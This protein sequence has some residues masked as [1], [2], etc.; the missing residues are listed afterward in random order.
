MS[1]VRPPYDTAS[2]SWAA[3]TSYTRPPAHAADETWALGEGAVLFVTIAP[4]ALPATFA[5]I[6]RPQEPNTLWARAL[7]RPEHLSAS[8][9][10]TT[11]VAAA[12][13]VS[14]GPIFPEP[15]FRGRERAYSMTFAVPAG[16]GPHVI[17]PA[18][19]GTGVT[20]SV[21]TAE[22]TAGV[23]PYII[24]PMLAGMVRQLLE[25]PDNDG[26]RLAATWRQG[27]RRAQPF[28]SRW[29][30]MQRTHTP[31]SAPQTHGIRLTISRTFPHADML[32]LRRR[33]ECPHAHGARLSR[34]LTYKHA[35]G[36]PA[37]RRVA[38][39][40]AHGI[41][42]RRIVGAPH[43]EAIRRRGKLQLDHQQ[44]LPLPLPWR[45]GHHQARTTA[46]PMGFRWAQM[47][48][49]APGRWWPFYEPPPLY[50][51]LPCA[52]GYVPRPLHC[53]VL[54]HWQPIEQPHCPGVDP[55]PPP[56]TPVVVPIQ[57]IYVVLN[58]V[59][60]VRAADGIEVPCESLAL[61]LDAGSWVWGFTARLPATAQERVE[62]G[63]D[64]VELL[65]WINGTAF[66]ILVESIARERVFADTHI[67]I[68]GRGHQAVLD[69]PYAPIQ[70]FANVGLRTSQQLMD[71]VL[72]VNGV[73][74]GWTIDWDLEAWMVPAG[75]FS[76]QGTYLSAL[77]QIARAGG[78]VLIPH[79]SLP[80][81]AVRHAYPVAPWDW[82]DVAPDL[83][84]PA[85]A[86]ARESLT[87][88]EKPIYNRVFVS[89]VSQGILGQVTRAGT[90]G[91]RVA[92][93]VVDP[94]I[95]APAAARQ[96][97]LA[98][99]ADT[100]RQLEVGLRLPVFPE[101]QIVS[102]GTFIEYEDE[103]L[104]RIGLVRSTQIDV[105]LPAVWQ[106]LGV[107]TRA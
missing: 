57:R 47:I 95:T 93:M 33:R 60:L 68:S 20:V 88:I 35:H 18:F 7:H 61:T 67:R 81:F 24:A 41:A 34:A 10:G 14:V 39:R 23:E 105:G 4:P 70:T 50:F 27:A 104:T 46:T 71:E 102:P 65:A 22:I 37:R 13:A 89:G 25:L 3:D 11:V 107:E 45:I 29:G 55:E 62:P 40:H 38:E 42:L 16:P 66:R 98:V 1:Y 100:G 74:L 56:L 28:W 53:T 73:S 51:V 103:G 83:V 64:P 59:Q 77:L 99:L 49:P 21:A 9:R 90:A 92:P 106:T 97:G 85:A 5:G 94:L 69:A 19:T 48:P 36:L 101:T 78:G 12:L 76:H 82:E 32:R 84:L 86:I 80:S 43:A 54:L 6:E 17:A 15:I 96:R 72:T 79:A 52:S 91:E 75:V 87:W 63:P 26:P 31:A 44:A 58:D 8:L 2:E 30:D